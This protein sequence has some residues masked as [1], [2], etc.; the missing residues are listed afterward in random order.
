M[1]FQTGYGFEENGVIEVVEGSEYGW[2]IPGYN[3]V[4]GGDDE[5]QAAPASTRLLRYQLVFDQDLVSSLIGNAPSA[6]FRVT[7]VSVDWRE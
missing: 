1:A 4:T 2:V 5:L 7:G 3:T 6:Y